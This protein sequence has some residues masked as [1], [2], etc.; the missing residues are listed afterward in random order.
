[1][2]A[3]GPPAA[4]VAANAVVVA[5][6]VGAAAVAFAAWPAGRRF[7][8]RRCVRVRPVVSFD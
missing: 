6:A 7:R 4:V 3:A 8:F 1:V 2:H 5:A